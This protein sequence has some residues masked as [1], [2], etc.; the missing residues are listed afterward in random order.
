MYI[1]RGYGSVDYSFRIDNNHR[2]GVTSFDIRYHGER[3]FVT[4]LESFDLLGEPLINF[5]SS[6]FKGMRIV[7]TRTIERFV[8]MSIS[9]IHTFQNLGD[10]IWSN[11]TIYVIINQHNRADGANAEA[12]SGFQS[13]FTIFAGFSWFDLQLIQESFPYF[14]TASHMAWRTFANLITC[15]PVGLVDIMW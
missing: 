6:F 14:F 5:F 3:N 10:L 7:G 1:I 15:L 9:P 12:A 13:P 2:G 4:E 11:I 8:F